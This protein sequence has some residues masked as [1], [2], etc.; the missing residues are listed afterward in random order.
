MHGKKRVSSSLKPFIIAGFL[1]LTIW[2]LSAFTLYFSFSNWQDRGT[3]GDMFGAVNAL[4]SGLAF[5]GVI[6]TILL[7]RKELVLQRKE[8]ELTRQEL[9]KSA[10]AQQKSEKSLSIQAKSML[11]SAKLNALTAV[12]KNYDQLISSGELSYIYK[13]TELLN[14]AEKL[15]EDLNKQ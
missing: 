4:F 12:V 6:Y 14:E 3:F 7:Q 9:R 11:A 8:L 5:S 1:V 2:L 15:L 13:R 10:E